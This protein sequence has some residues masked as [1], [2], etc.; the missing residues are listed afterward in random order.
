MC[1][2]LSKSHRVLYMHSL[3]EEGKVVNPKQIEN[4]FSISNRTLQRDIDE[5]RCFYSNR[6]CL[7]GNYSVIEYDRVTRGYVLRSVTG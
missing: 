2:M 4:E 7:E 1:E 6:G 3:L 5:L